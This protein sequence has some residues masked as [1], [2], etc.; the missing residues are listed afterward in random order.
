MRQSCETALRGA[1]MQANARF[2][3]VTNRIAGHV[4]LKASI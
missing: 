2:A 1:G 3:P 4:L